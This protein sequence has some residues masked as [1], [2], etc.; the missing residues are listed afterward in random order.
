MTQIAI[1]FFALA[2]VAA[3]SSAPPDDD[4]PGPAEPASEPLEPGR[5]RLV[6]FYDLRPIDWD[7]GKRVPLTAGDGHECDRCGREHAKCYEVADDSSGRSWILGVRC[8]G[9]A[10]DGWHPGKPVLAAARKA[11]REAAR[12]AARDRMRAHAEGFAA[13]LIMRRGELPEPVSTFVDEPV[14]CEDRTKRVHRVAGWTVYAASLP[15]EGADAWA[16]RR[17]C[18][19]TIA[20]KLEQDQPYSR[21][22]REMVDLAVSIAIDLERN[23]HR[24]AGWIRQALR[25]VNNPAGI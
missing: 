24:V 17:R 11:E 8:M 9:R 15:W 14:P 5:F 25:S 13:A 7:T 21:A 20:R 23:D 16:L 6:A 12:A 22:R 4:E 18:Y 3:C 10:L 19:T 2:A 1:D